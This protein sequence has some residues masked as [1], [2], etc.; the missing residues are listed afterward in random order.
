MRRQSWNVVEP[1]PVSVNARPRQV[2]SQNRDGKALDE[3]NPA[4][5]VINYAL[6]HNFAPRTDEL[7]STR[8]YIP[9][10]QIGVSRPYNPQ[11][12]NSQGSD[13]HTGLLSLTFT[14]FV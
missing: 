1:T 6:M 3:P 12:L 10:E 4:A 14:L 13:R 5:L 2:Q 11:L 8:R 9:G 7:A